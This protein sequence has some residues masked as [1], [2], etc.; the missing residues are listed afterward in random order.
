[1]A[2]KEIGS[3]EL[4]LESL[5]SCFSRSPSEIKVWTLTS[6]NID[7]NGLLFSAPSD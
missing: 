6:H 7:F 3:S 2:I 1:M 4:V 5:A